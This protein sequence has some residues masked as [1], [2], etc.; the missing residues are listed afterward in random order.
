LSGYHNTAIGYGALKN[1][2]AGVNTAVGWEAL[3]ANV[4]GINNTAIGQRALGSNIGG[5]RNTATGVQALAGLNAGDDNTAIGEDALLYNA[6]GSGNTAAG[7][8]SGTASNVP[9]ANNTV[10]IGN[11]GYLNGASN[12]AFLGNLSTL[13]NGGNKVWSTFSDARIKNH[14]EEDVKG[15]DFILRLRPVTYYR[16]I[17]AAIAITGDHET[18]D[19]PEKYDVEKIKESGFLAQEVEQATMESGYNFSGITIPKKS[20]ELYTLSYESFVVPLVKAVQELA[21]QNTQLN[22][23]C[24]RYRSA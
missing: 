17:S 2:N 5:Q 12:Q 23:G 15:L 9:N 3:V 20:H 24:P 14:I 16:S 1:N 19:Y 10:S 21:E 11:H 18:R 22:C 13:W 6:S 8:S 4:S 7:A